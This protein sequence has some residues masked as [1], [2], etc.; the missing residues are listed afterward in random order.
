MQIE[1]ATFA[2]GCFWGVEAT[3]RQLEGVTTQVGYTGGLT[4]NPTYKEVCTDKTGHAE[5]VEVTFDPSRLSYEEL[6]EIFFKMHDAS[7]FNRQ[8]P[9]V[10]QQYRSAVFYHSQQQKEIVEKVKARVQAEVYKSK[11]IMTK[12]IP[13]STFY[14]AEAYHQQYFEKSG[15]HACVNYLPLPKK[16][17]KKGSSY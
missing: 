1:K 11:K 12:I 14:P 4:P 9:D 17:Q 6:V 7:Q 16:N 13:A 5:A 15:F 8:G 2:A 10:G 3:F